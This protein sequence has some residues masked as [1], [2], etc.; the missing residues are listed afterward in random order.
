MTEKGLVIR[1]ESQRSHIYEAAEKAESTQR[2]LVVDLLKN[3]F[4][5]RPGKLVIQA[6]SEQRATPE[7]LDEIKRLIDSMDKKSSSRKQKK[8]GTQE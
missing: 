4:G 1:N 2:S 6:L 7:E 5:G 3:A 8:K